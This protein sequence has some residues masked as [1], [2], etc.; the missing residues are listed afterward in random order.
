MKCPEC[1][2]EKAYV[3][4]TKGWKGALLKTAMLLPMKCQ[5]CYHRFYA[6]RLLTIGKRLHPP[7]LRVTPVSIESGAEVRSLSFSDDLCVQNRSL[8]RRAA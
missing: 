4:Q 8:E 2:T 1:W 6:F 5:H 7:V 3:R